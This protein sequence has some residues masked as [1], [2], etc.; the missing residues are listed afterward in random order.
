MLEG[1]VVGSR[2]I[3]AG[4]CI[5][6]EAPLFVLSSSRTIEDVK[7]AISHLSPAATLAFN[8]LKLS[9]ATQS[10]TVPSD[11]PPDALAL[12]NSNC[13]PL[14][15]S[16][17]PFE[18]EPVTGSGIFPILNKLEHSCSPNTG[19]HYEQKLGRILVHAFDSISEKVA[20]TISLVDPFLTR[21]ERQERLERR[22]GIDCSCKACSLKGEEAELS[23]HRRERIKTLFVEMPDQNDASL[24]IRRCEEALH[25]LR[26]EGI[27]GWH[28][29]WCYDG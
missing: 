4:E 14:G 6:S 13:W 26:D 19:Y 17:Y 10:N 24:A 11:V 25:L 7:L 2:K 15:D 9:R 27:K 29:C 20:I 3:E 5:L 1:K 23:D 28:G 22:F 16:M 21:A 12:F 8:S 18:T